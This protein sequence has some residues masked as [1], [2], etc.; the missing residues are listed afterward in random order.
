MEGRFATTRWSLVLTAGG[1]ATAGSRAALSELCELYWRPVYAF[2]RRQG[3]DVHEAEDMTQAF[4]AR[5][6][7]KHVVQAADPQRGR[8][9]S[10]L[11]A[12]FK[13]FIA[14]ERDR[15]RAQKRGSG[16]VIVG[17]DVESAEARYSSEPVDTLT[18]EALF[19]RQWA[20]SVLDRVLAALRDECV[21]AGKATVFDAVR[22]LLAGDRNPG[23]YA[24]L[25]GSLGTTEGALKVH[26]HRLRRRYR[27]L[28][29]A[30]IEGTVSDTSEVDD[31]I[32]Y[33]MAVVS[34]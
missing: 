2:A 30:E 23:G 4:F 16:Q 19:E 21:K 7:E 26:V 3:F 18:P 25:A 15:A 33:L 32:G 20:L 5:L 27:E 29:R 12:S 13:H 14:N 10:F 34:R 24:A 8:F 6:L 1:E 17:L 28:L 31:E 9:R 11:L 22:D